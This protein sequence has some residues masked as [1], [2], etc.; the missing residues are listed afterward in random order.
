VTDIAELLRTM[1][2][3]I[4]ATRP[5]CDYSAAHKRVDDADIKTLRDAAD[6][7]RALRT[8]NDEVFAASIKSVR[9]VAELAIELR[10]TKQ[11]VARLLDVETGHRVAIASLTAERDEARAEVCAHEADTLEDQQAYAKLR[12]WQCFAHTDGAQQ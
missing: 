3:N 12:G 4:D 2:D 8:V 5:E 10:E 1:A 11:E 9:D 6:L 7:I